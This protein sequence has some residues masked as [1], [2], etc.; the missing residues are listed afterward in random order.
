VRIILN[1][2]PYPRLVPLEEEETVTRKNKARIA[3]VLAVALGLMAIVSGGSVL[4]GI[5]T[6]TYHVIPWLVL[7]NVLMGFV[8]VAAGIGLWMEKKWAAMV[9]AI[10]LV[11]HGA[12]L[13][14]LGSMYL[15]GK[16]VAVFSIKAMVFRTVMWTVINLM[17]RGKKE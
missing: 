4:L 13:I 14:S 15:L 11:C 8:S 17:V 6:K 2:L 12:V 9:A 16:A 5:E 3:A 1:C 10:I 7:Y